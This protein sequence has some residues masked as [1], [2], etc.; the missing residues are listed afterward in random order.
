MDLPKLYSEIA[1]IDY[2]RTGKIGK[3][4]EIAKLI[5]ILALTNPPNLDC[6]SKSLYRLAKSEK[7]SPIEIVLEKIR[8]TL[9]TTNMSL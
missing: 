2:D 4:L 7:G 3:I 8:E 6:L 5:K 1:S 9:K